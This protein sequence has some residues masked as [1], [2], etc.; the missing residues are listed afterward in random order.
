MR[1]F[2]DLESMRV[3][4][5]ILVI[6]AHVTRMYTPKAAIN[7]N[8]N[9]TCFCWLTEWI[10][11]FHMPAFVLISGAV[12]YFIKRDKGGYNNSKAFILS[13]AKR[14]L[15]PYIFFSFIIVLPTLYYCSLTEGSFWLYNFKTFI[16]AKAPRHL[17]YLIMLFNILILFN[18]FEKYIFKYKEITLLLTLILHPFAFSFPIDIFQVPSTIYYSFYFMLGYY[19][20]YNRNKLITYLNKT[21][22]IYVTSALVFFSIIV[23]SLSHIGII[24]SNI[25]SLICSILG[26][27]FIYIISNMISQKSKITNNFIYKTISMNNFGIYLFH[28]MIIY[29]LFYNIRNLNL[30]PYISTICIFIISTILSIL[31]TLFFRKIGLKTVLGEK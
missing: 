30:N 15:I 5:M 6:F 19:F 13:K 17:W 1:K 20:Q 28:P 29:I 10:Y 14:L 22:K 11:T 2:E 4:T 9:N 3:I 12:Y 23:Y 7:L 31:L 26:I 25:S 21:N 27:M 8:I 16:L 24:K 18:Y